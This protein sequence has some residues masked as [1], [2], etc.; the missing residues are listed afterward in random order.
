[1]D[2]TPSSRRESRGPLRRNR[3]AIVKL[4]LGGFALAG[5]GAAATSA[6]WTDS[7]FFSSS[8]SSASVDL[9]GSATGGANTN[10]IAADTSTGVTVDLGSI[11]NLTPDSSIAKTLYLWNASSA[12]LALTWGAANPATLIDPACVTVTYSTLPAS[13]PGDPNGALAG[14]KITATVTVKML[15]NAPQTTCS[16]KSASLVVSVQGATTATIVP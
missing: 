1:M 14:S 15:T 10:F 9:R 7:A 3:G 6:A 4:T 5:I 2:T 12:P 11:S 13:V 8:V 16:G